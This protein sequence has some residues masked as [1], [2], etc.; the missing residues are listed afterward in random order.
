M[1][2]IINI[3]HIFR[4]KRLDVHFYY[5]PTLP[6]SIRLLI[7]TK[8]FLLQHTNKNKANFFGK[9]EKHSAVI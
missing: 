4:I 5:N 7:N 1:I 3:R 6:F 8:E 9:I 2:T